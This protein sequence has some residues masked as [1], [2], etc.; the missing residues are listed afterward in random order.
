MAL[1]PKLIA[2]ENDLYPI[3]DVDALNNV[4]SD[5]AVGAVVL[6]D[7][8]LPGSDNSIISPGTS[9]NLALSNTPRYLSTGNPARAG[10]RSR[11]TWSTALS[12]SIAPSIPS[13]AYIIPSTRIPCL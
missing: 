12:E 5:L 6:I 13:E 9:S 4:G 11:S 3:W 1:H 7:M 2:R 8:T 10:P